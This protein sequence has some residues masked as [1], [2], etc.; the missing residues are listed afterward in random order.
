MQLDKGQ[1]LMVD[2]YLVKRSDHHFHY[3]ESLGID[4]I[5]GRNGFIWIG[6]HAQTQDPMIQNTGKEQ[7]HTPLETR[8][9]ILRIGNVIRVL[10]NLGFTMTLEVIMETFNLSNTESIN[11]HDMLGSEFHV[12][13]AEKEVDRRRSA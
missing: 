8:K 4:L 2:P 12:L 7:S 13:V 1:L 6:E 10:S 9:N 5:I 3:I 11:V